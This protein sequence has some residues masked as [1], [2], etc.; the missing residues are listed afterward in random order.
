MKLELFPFQDTALN[1]LRKKTAE[2]MY[3]FERTNSSQII[4]FTAPT[5]AGKTIIITALIEKIFFGDADYPEQ[6]EAIF[7]WLSDSPELNEQSKQKIETK[8][9]KIKLNQ[10]ITIEN[11]SFDQEFLSDGHIY[12]LNTQKLS[13]SSNLTK[14]GNNREYTIWDTIRNTAES[15]S[16]RLYFIIDEAHRGAKSRDRAEATSIMQKFIKGSV[17]DSIKSMP[18]VIGMSATSERFN[19]LIAGTSSSIHNVVVPIEDVRASGLLKEKIIITYPDE[20][21]ANK[22]MAVLQAATDEW[23]RKWDHWYQYCT[24]QH[25]S[26]VNPVFV[27]Q[28]KN[29]KG[30]RIS[31][32]SLDESLLQIEKR[33]DYKFKF[34]EV[35]HS[36]GDING[37]LQVN[38]LKVPY[39]EPSR[40]NDNRNIRIVFFKESL[41]TGWDCPRAETMMSFR[42]ANDSTYIAQLLG[43]MVRT[44]KQMRIQVDE[45]LNDVYLFLPHFNQNNVDKVVE[46]FQSSEGDSVPA[47]VE[48]QKIGVLSYETWTVKPVNK[49]NRKP[50]NI[51]GQLQFEPES[52]NEKKDPTNQPDDIVL[53]PL[54]EKDEVNNLPD[55]RPTPEEIHEQR[56]N[57]DEGQEA[58]PDNDVFDVDTDVIDREEITKFINE[59]GLLTYQVRKVQITNYLASLFKLS[60]L[61]LQSNLDLSENERIVEEIVEII[62]AYI[63]KLKK[64]NDYSKLKKELLEF[65]LNKKVLDV[66]GE[67]IEDEG[68]GGL[69]SSSNIDVERQFRQAE[70]KLNNEGIGQRYGQK[71]F[72]IN[73]PDEYK[74]HVILFAFDKNNI[75]Y[76]HEYAKE[77]FH[78]L[79]DKFRRYIPTL[80][81]VF[82]NQYEK[83]SSNSDKVSQ[84]NFRLP[85]T[86]SVE[87]K[88][89][90][91]SYEDHLLVNQ[92][93]GV[94][95]VNLNDWEEQVLEEERKRD[96]FVCW[97]RNPSRKPWAL[98]IP[99]E[100]DNE[101]KPMYP[102]LIII[103]KDPVLKYVVDIIEPHGQ[104]LAD[105][106]GKAK[107]LAEYARQNPGLGRIEL[108]RIVDSPSKR[109]IFLRL[110][111]AKTKIRDKVSKINTYE[112]LENLFR[113]YGN[114]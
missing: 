65:R 5:G 10:C 38:G 15:K 83:I 80:P 29:R 76:L 104:H 52:S 26:H 13:S 110:D 8:S 109:T 95:H 107:G 44:P 87:S 82:Q 18:L 12:F 69:F 41:S 112:E 42:S 111:M 57:S 43:R 47:E 53:L 37:S 2:A 114:K 77:K 64:N 63:Q 102:D 70:A 88:P 67:E 34:G 84:H 50:K 49:A 39:I 72:E 35:V 92:S 23:K 98:Q 55:L 99:Y 21:D 48:G 68:L 20:S 96:D 101:T 28:V 17:V 51:S 90:Y 22:D 54:C 16:D 58:E 94:A 71:Y 103:R 11:E 73:D 85:A 66:F 62:C 6:P 33:L 46:A 31:E 78:E 105:N 97:L 89:D 61:L 7:V 45:T 91:K 1:N 100:I 14:Y 30:D 106:V 59:S 75:D 27:I 32:T 36:F 60:R 25:Y 24:E 40:I 93:T 56:N 3:F 81:E 113:N 19:T 4:S 74:I 108:V 86:I 9:D 79:N